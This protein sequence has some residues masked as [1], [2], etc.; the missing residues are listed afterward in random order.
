MIADEKTRRDR[1]I[2]RG[3]KKEN[4]EQRITNDVVDFSLDKIGKVDFIIKTT[5]KSIEEI[6]DL[7]YKNYKEKI[8]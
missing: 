1:M 4:I 2:S 6:A 5:D 8:N 3:D 7:I